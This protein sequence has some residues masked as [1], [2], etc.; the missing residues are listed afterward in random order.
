MYS[1]TAHGYKINSDIYFQQYSDYDQSIECSHEVTVRHQ[2]YK[3]WPSIQYSPLSTATTKINNHEFRLRLNGIGQ[4][5][6]FRN[7]CIEWSK[8]NSG[9]SNDDITTFLSTSCLPVFAMQSGD[10]VL[11]GTS[12]VKN[13]KTIVLLGMPVSG[14]STLAFLMCQNGWSLLSSEITCVRNFTDIYPGIH[15]LKLWHNSVTQLGL[16]QR[17]MMKVRPSIE[18]YIVAPSM[19]PKAYQPYNL[20]TIFVLTRQIE[21]PQEDLEEHIRRYF[22]NPEMYKLEPNLAMYAIRENVLY[23]RVYRGMGLEIELFKAIANVATNI[24][25][26]PL[27]VPE[28]IENLSA[29]VKRLDSFT[30]LLRK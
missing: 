6:S 11:A 7:T 15:Q 12:L 17:T 19:T 8:S 1:F 29:W 23:P 28:G 18:R 30:N 9:V 21:G 22:E 5:R 20:D 24:P 3:K 27:S 16:D 2:D 10:L 26:Y 13:G 25:V 4:F 14:K